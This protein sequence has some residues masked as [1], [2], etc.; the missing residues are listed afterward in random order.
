MVNGGG[1]RLSYGPSARTATTSGQ[2]FPVRTSRSVSKRLISHL[3]FLGIHTGR[4]AR[5]IT[6]TI[7]KC[8]FD[9]PR[10]INCIVIFKCY[11]NTKIIPNY[12]N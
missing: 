10:Y 3:Y 6:K 5:V 12:L 4:K 11:F 1:G 2:Y 8:S 7:H 9:I